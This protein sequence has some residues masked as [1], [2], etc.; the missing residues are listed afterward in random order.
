MT[1]TKSIALG[2]VVGLK[3]QKQKFKLLACGNADGSEILPFLTIGNSTQPRFFN[4]QSGAQLGFDYHSNK[5]VWMMADIFRYWLGR[6]DAY[7]A[8]TESRKIALLLD[9][10]KVR[11]TASNHAHLSY[12]ELVYLPPN[13][14]SRLQPLEAGIIAAIKHRY[15]RGYCAE[16]FI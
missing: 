12:L 3:K 4:S 16:H 7:V 1:P 13:I 8:A 14:T 2:P 10:A 11:G 15:D 6:L 5:K 9:N